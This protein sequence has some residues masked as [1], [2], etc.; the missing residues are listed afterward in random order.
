MNLFLISF[1]ILSELVR[2]FLTILLWSRG[3]STSPM[4]VPETAVHEYRQLVLGHDYV[5]PA[6]QLPDMQSIPKPLGVQIVSYLQFRLGIFSPNSRHHARPG[7]AIDY[8]HHSW[9]PGTYQLKVIL[10]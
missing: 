3:V 2:P 1:N 5:R 6:R 4:S 8:V 9:Y 7:S 10:Q